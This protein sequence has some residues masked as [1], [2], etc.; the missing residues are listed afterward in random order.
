MPVSNRTA[1]VVVYTTIYITGAIPFCME[2]TPINK[3]AKNPAHQY[4]DHVSSNWIVVENSK[5]LLTRLIWS[6]GKLSVCDS[7]SLK[8][9]YHLMIVIPL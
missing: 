5:N 6:N 7:K 8:S 2:Q 9:A 4:L 3:G 1:G